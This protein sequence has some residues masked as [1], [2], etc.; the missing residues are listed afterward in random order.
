M[1]SQVQQ[2]KETAGP[3]IVGVHSS[4]RLQ[5]IGQ[6]KQPR[7]IAVTVWDKTWQD[8]TQ[9]MSTRDH[10]TFAWLGFQFRQEQKKPAI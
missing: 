1:E 9:G 7:E 2:V 5:C 8:A 4:Q 3:E 10:V 6:I